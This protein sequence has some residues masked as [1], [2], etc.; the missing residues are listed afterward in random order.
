MSTGNET[1]LRKG[2]ADPL[3]SVSVLIPTYNYAHFLSQAIDSVLAQTIQP[4]EIM[5]A[6]DGSTDHTAEVVARY[7][8]AVQYRRFDHRGVFSIRQA[9]LPEL[10]GDWFLNLDADDWIDPDF[11]EKALHLVRRRSGEGRLAFVYADRMDFGAYDRVC[12]APEF[13]VQLFKQGNFV[14]MDSLVH[15]AT[16]RQFGF[17]SAFNAG[18]GDYDFFLTLA[19][20][21]FIGER[22]AGSRIHCRVHPASIT[23]ATAEAD[24]KQRLMRQI[25]AKHGDFFS[26]EEGDRAIR[27]FSPESVLRYRICERI[28]AGKP[29]QA[30]G[31]ALRLLVTN[32]KALVSTRAILGAF[33]HWGGGAGAG[34]N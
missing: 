5:V 1:S 15:T 17:D 12:T 33:R 4:L 29:V 6:D 21:G 25:V 16:A 14:A 2:E 26:P 8:A 28:W 7:G 24:R 13:D 11:L 9:L 23:E 32:P 31:M 27:R 10:K 34:K 20:N 30:A 22:L 3:P 19:K 18:W